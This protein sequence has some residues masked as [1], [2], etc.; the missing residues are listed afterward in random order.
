MFPGRAHRLRMATEP[1]RRGSPLS[2]IDRARLVSAI[3]AYGLRVVVA[4]CATRRTTLASAL[5]G[6][7]VLEGTH[8]LVQRGLERLD[9]EAVRQKQAERLARE[10]GGQP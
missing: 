2:P 8:A 10:S 7:N 6:L 9:R 4:A 5:G 1:Q 3:H